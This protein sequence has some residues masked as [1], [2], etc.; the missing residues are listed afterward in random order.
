M[1]T[2]RRRSTLELLAELLERLAHIRISHMHFSKEVICQSSVVIKATKIRAAHVADLQFLMTGRT[3]GI[4]KVLQFPLI[5]LFLVLGRADL[6]QFVERDGHGTSLAQD[7]DLEQSR[8]DGFG[9][10][11]DLFELQ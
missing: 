5:G 3:R 6:M 4:L 9:E 7:G 2:N 1:V 8:V 11:R 10:I